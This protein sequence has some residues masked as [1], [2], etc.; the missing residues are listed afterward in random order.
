MLIYISRGNPTTALRVLRVKPP[1]GTSD[2]SNHMCQSVFKV[3]VM[4]R[5]GSYGNPVFLSNSVSMSDEWLVESVQRNKSVLDVTLSS[6]VISC[7]RYVPTM[8]C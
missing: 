1:K 5:E 8:Y 6:N 3:V 2:Y 4:G 7:D